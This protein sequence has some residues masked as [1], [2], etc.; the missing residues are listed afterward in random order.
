MWIG[1]AAVP[2]HR[3]H[4]QEGFCNTLVLFVLRYTTGGIA[5]RVGLGYLAKILRVLGAD[6]GI[7]VHLPG[8]EGIGL[9]CEGKAS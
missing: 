2:A 5:A 4:H 7:L 8:R 3:F 1:F 6:A 9:R